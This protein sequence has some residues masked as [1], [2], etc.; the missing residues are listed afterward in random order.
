MLMFGGLAVRDLYLNVLF[1]VNKHPVIVAMA[2]LQPV[3]PLVGHVTVHVVARPAV[4]TA[5]LQVVQTDHLA[6]TWVHRYLPSNRP[7][8][9][10]KT[11][12]TPADITQTGLQIIRA[13]VKKE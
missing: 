7:C 12:F 3:Q 4:G 6:G 10:S 8:N 9:Y 11:S 5:T 13:T 1:G 2:T